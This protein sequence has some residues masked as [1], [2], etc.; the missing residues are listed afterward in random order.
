MSRKGINNQDNMNTKQ[1]ESLT[2]SIPKFKYN[3][4]N[5]TNTYISKNP[6]TTKV[7]TFLS[8]TIRRKFQKRENTLKI[9]K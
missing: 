9:L 2:Y 6:D 4:I 7:I 8:S 5:R 1:N 3:K